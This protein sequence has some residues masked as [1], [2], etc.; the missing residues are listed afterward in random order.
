MVKKLHVGNLGYSV[1]E[2]ALRAAFSE[3]GTV[4]SAVVVKDRVSGRSKGFGFVE[5]STD[6]EAAEAIEKLNKVDFKGRTIFVS[7]SRYNGGPNG[8]GD[9]DGGGRSGHSPYGGGGGGGGYK[10]DRRPPRG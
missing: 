8:G 4:E 1:T 9:R 6:A 7:E 2:E 5:M 3:Y 10:N